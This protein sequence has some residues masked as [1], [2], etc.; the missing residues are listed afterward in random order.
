MHNPRHTASHSGDLAVVEKTYLALFNKAVLRFSTDFLAVRV[1]IKH[2]NHLFY[3][4][5]SCEERYICFFKFLSVMS[6][7]RQRLPVLLRIKTFKKDI[8]YLCYAITKNTQFITK[9]SL[10]LLIMFW[11]N[12]EHCK[13][14]E[15]LLKWNIVFSCTCISILNNLQYFKRLVSDGAIQTKTK[16]K[17][18]SKPL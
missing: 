18:S 8:F 1:F 4:L 6:P 16:S 11:S 12:L 3:T 5:I 7:L 15:L 14:I 17:S 10:T 2:K 9:T 13:K